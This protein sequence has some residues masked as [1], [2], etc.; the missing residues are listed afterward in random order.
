M[1]ENSARG[2]ERSA[3]VAGRGRSASGVQSTDRRRSSVVE[4]PPCKRQ[5]V[6]SIQTGG[7]RKTRHFRAVAFVPNAVL[8]RLYTAPPNGGHGL[9]VEQ[10]R[11]TTEGGSMPPSFFAQLSMHMRLT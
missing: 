10:A 1:R 3:S 5:V 2:F 8:Y 6:C 7:I 11:T 4:Q 9:S